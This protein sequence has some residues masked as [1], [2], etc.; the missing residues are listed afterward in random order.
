MRTEYKPRADEAQGEG[1]TVTNSFAKECYFPC[2]LRLSI[3]DS[4]HRRACVLRNSE[5]A[6][7]L[8][9]AISLGADR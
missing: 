4:A 1:P 6:V 2:V 8:A 9:E 3:F 7:I 5:R